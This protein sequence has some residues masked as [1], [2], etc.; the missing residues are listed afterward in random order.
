[1]KEKADKTI[2]QPPHMLPATHIPSSKIILSQEN[3]IYDYKIIRDH[4][5]NRGLL[6]NEQ[7][8]WILD[9][10][11]E[12]Q[13]KEPNLIYIDK[14]CFI[15][16]D[17]HG[18]YYDLMNILDNEFE[19]NEFDNNEIKS[20]EITSNEIKSNEFDNNDFDNNEIKRNEIKSSG[21]SE[22]AGNYKHF[23]N[24]KPE[25]YV[26]PID[27]K[28][29]SETVNSDS[30]NYKNASD[31]NSAIN[32]KD[33]AFL[34]LGD[35][36]DRGM[37]SC[38]TYIYLLMLKITFPDR[39]FMLRGNH[40]AEGM[41]THFSFKKECLKKYGLPIYTKFLENFRSLPIAAV[42]LQKIFCVHGGISPYL[43]KIENINKINR[44]VEP[45]KSG[46]LTDL[47]WSDPHPLFEFNFVNSFVHN[48]NRRCSYFYSEN[49]VND[50]LK[51]NNLWCIVRGHE[52]QKEGFRIYSRYSYSPSVYRYINK[53]SD[54]EN[55][56]EEIL[57]Q[58]I[59]IENR[60]YE[61]DKTD[62][63][64]SDDTLLKN[65]KENKEKI[66]KIKK[67][68][69]EEKSGENKTEVKRFDGNKTDAKKFDENKTDVKNKPSDKENKPTDKENEGS[70][71]NEESSLLGE[72]GN[73]KLGFEKGEIIKNGLIKMKNE[74]KNAKNSIKRDFKSCEPNPRPHNFPCVITI[75]SAPNYCDSY[76]NYGASL[77][78][79][80]VDF[81]I[82]QYSEVDHP[83]LLPGFIDPINWSFPFVSQKIGSL[84]EEL[85]QINDIETVSSS[86]ASV[87]NAFEE[88]AEF[89]ENMEELR[90]RVECIGE[91][92]EEPVPDMQLNSVR[93]DEVSFEESKVLDIKNEIF[94]INDLK[95][96][97]MD[98]GFD[99]KVFIEAKEG[100][101]NDIP[102]SCIPIRVADKMN[103]QM[104]GKKQKWRILGY[105]RNVFSGIVGRIK[106]LFVS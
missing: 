40:E 100:F 66:E 25:N 67:E 91:I 8:A 54:R 64:S 28:K 51:N 6:S 27:G 15:Y 86:S 9:K 30:Q 99:K 58:G 98:L 23:H 24:S 13:S 60:H 35:Y 80:G 78:F 82:T 11:Y 83:Y 18:Q 89:K 93:N 17:L 50:F 44:F 97:N 16:G 102:P 33:K 81:R 105:F 56:M 103:G 70:N 47:L 92:V 21:T 29:D 22:L 62:S 74:Q 75:F 3:P 10:S 59:N 49:A 77:F 14:E 31:N 36:V 46:L 19:N 79:N 71:N 55:K 76:K 53:R 52:V 84:L 7:V 104:K 63:L 57:Y 61:H 94:D 1:M 37:F 73:S 65:M 96:E 72:N 34:F 42:V 45:E 88:I 5:R 41:T 95:F 87:D 69:E 43:T 39:I 85:L 38:E 26:N 32:K 90:S 4:F 48:T 68:L 106:N 101:F 12:I 2:L 20:N